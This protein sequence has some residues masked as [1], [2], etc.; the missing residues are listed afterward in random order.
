MVK[1]KRLA[2]L[3]L[4]GFSCTC[5]RALAEAR[6]PVPSYMFSLDEGQQ[7]VGQLQRIRSRHEDTFADLARLFNLGYDEL[8]AAN[9]GVDPWLPGEGTEIILPTQ[10][11]LPEAPREG[12]VLNLA[13]M[14]LFYFP[15]P[16]DDGRR[17]VYTHPIGIGRVGWSTPLGSTMVNAKATNPAWYVPESV[18]AEHAAEGDPLPRVVPPGPDN[19]LG[20][21]VLRLGMPG[22][23]IHGTN[24][25]WGV[26]MRVSHGCIRLYPEDIAALY[27]LVPKGTAVH[28]VDQPYVA[29]WSGHELVFS[30]RKPL[31]E[32]GGDWLAALELIDRR[33][34]DAPDGAPDLSVDW[35]RVARVTREGLGV[36]MPVATG[37]ED[38]DEMLARAPLVRPLAVAYYQPPAP[39]E[40][41]TPEG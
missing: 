35:G 3:F 14:R 10:F 32:R 24:K 21:H 13:S 15:P 4:I 16:D 6:D 40:V 17:V 8:S 11:V 22:Y 34:N 7:V 36:P 31:E 38:P 33:L 5:G 2:A 9:P 12:L 26:G 18:L 20:K 37:S 41:A 30:A 1:G 28:I 19:P 39:E 25:P 23:L 29:G 27:E